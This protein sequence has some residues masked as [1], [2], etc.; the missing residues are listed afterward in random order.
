MKQYV[1]IKVNMNHKIVYKYDGKDVK[2]ALL[3]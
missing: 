3:G 1:Q 2:A